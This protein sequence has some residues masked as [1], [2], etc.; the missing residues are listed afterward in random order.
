MMRFRRVLARILSWILNP[1]IPG[2]EAPGETPGPV[3][4]V[5]PEA[6][7]WITARIGTR[8][9]ASQT[10]IRTS[11]HTS[12]HTSTGTSPG[13][14]HKT[15]RIGREPPR[16]TYLWQFIRGVLFVQFVL[17]ATWNNSG[18]SYVGWVRGAASFT[19]LMAVVGI[20]LLIAHIVLIRIAYVA[21]GYAGLIGASLSVGALMLIGSQLNLIVLNDLSRHIEF[22]LFNVAS[23]ISVGVGWAKYQ[24]RFS[25]QREV[26]K[27]PP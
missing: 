10:S 20:A 3:R 4:R 17:F 12:T 2:Q 26:L 21:L 19:A 13:A 1:T 8:T 23:I 18:Y 15:R 5:I 6:I 16:Q 24:Q 27:N 11:T 7:G 25:G 22:W 9:S 14:P